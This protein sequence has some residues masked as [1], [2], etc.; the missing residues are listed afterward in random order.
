MIKD[1]LNL[2]FP[3]TCISCHGLIVKQ[4]ELWCTY[5]SMR[6]PKTNF[7]L[8]D[9]NPLMDRFY[10]KIPIEDVLA[11]LKF[12][13]GGMVQTL[14]HQ[15]K[16]KQKREVGRVLARWF[17]HDLQRVGRLDQVDLIIPVP[18]HRNK[19]KKRGYNQSHIFGLAMAKA[20]NIEYKN[21]NLI[22]ITDN[23]A[24]AKQADRLSRWKN[25]ADNFMVVQG[26]GLKNKHVLLVDDVL[27]TG[28]TLEAS[29]IPLLDSG[30]KS[31]RIA[32]IAAAF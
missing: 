26:E 8:M 23:S 21:D 6:L 24:Q 32:T 19:L 28:A 7:H 22:R 9:N 29:A 20:A 31:L 2:L 25:V 30:I 18:L 15:F 13:K 11:Y 3:R 10:G 16:Y 17:V 4:E 27:T 12:V 5:C 1:F 14:M